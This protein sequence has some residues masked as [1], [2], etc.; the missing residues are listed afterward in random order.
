MGRRMLLTGDDIEEICTVWK[1]RADRASRE[2]LARN[3]N[4]HPKDMCVLSN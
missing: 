1:G 2:A 3:K 4:R